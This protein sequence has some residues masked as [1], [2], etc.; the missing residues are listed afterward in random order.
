MPTMAAALGVFRFVRLIPLPDHFEHAAT[1]SPLSNYRS[2][3]LDSIWDRYE[4]FI[5]RHG[6]L[7][8]AILWRNLERL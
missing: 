2:S 3:K 7:L 6:L 1:P 5:R 4:S 8:T